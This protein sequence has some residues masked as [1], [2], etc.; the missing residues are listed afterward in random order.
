ML[1]LAC[2]AQNWQWAKTFGSSYNGLS[3]DE[4]SNGVYNP[5]NQCIYQSSNYVVSSNEDL[6]VTKMDLNGNFYSHIDPA[7]CSITNQ[8][9]SARFANTSY[10]P[11][12]DNPKW[13]TVIPTVFEGTSVRK[14]EDIGD[15]LI[16]GTI[17]SIINVA[18]V[19]LPSLPN[20][21]FFFSDTGNVYLREDVQNKRIYQKNP[22]AGLPDSL[23][24]DFNLNV[25]DSFPGV[26]SII[27]TSIDSALTNVGYRKRF[28]FT[29]GGDSIIWIEGVGN[30]TNP[31]GAISWYY[32][33]GFHVICS[34]QHDTLVYDEGSLYSINCSSLTTSI[35]QFINNNVSSLSVYPNPTRNSFSV[36]FNLQ[37]SE[38]V[39]IL[40]I[41][42][43]GNINKT[44]ISNNQFK[45]GQNELK[46]T[47]QL[48]PGIY[49][50]KLISKSGI[51][52]AKVCITS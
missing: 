42:A 38:K 30:I 7:F 27:L 1:S 36:L 33:P 2:S 15:T 29:Y 14:I 52:I 25:G 21:Y 24:Y 8:L 34:Y 23:I 26:P 35:N 39:E 32:Y 6:L 40:L 37:Q 41:D 13:Y 12:L 45:S 18:P 4:Y 19:N 10:Y 50:I 44:I 17:Y 5:V 28:I 31:L 16:N 51:Q 9:N 49:F 48:K 47:D 22:I 46:L 20:T 11:L 3:A 43:F